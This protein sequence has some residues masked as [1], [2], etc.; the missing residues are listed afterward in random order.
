M[1][2]HKWSGG[3]VRVPARETPNGNDQTERTCATCGLV[4]ITV[5][6]PR[7]F[8]WPE[9]RRPGGK[10]FRCEMTP[11]CIATAVAIDAASAMSG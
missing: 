1:P 11:G 10:Q 8:P 4:K 5:K 2:N 6:P 9:W 3:M 7:G